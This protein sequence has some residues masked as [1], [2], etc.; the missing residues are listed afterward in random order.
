MREADE[1]MMSSYRS[2]T[3]TGLVAPGGL[4]LLAPD[5]AA[6][7][8]R[9]LWEAMVA[10]RPL[11]AWLEAIAGGSLSALPDF[12]LVRTE[13]TQVRVLV[14]GQVSVDCDGTEIRAEGMSTWREHVGPLPQRLRVSGPED[15][16][17]EWPLGSGVVAAAAVQSGSEDAERSALAGTA[18]A[19]EVDTDARKHTPVEGGPE[20]G[21]LTPDE[22]E[23]AEEPETPAE[24]EDAGAA[25]T[26]DE[27]DDAAESDGGTAGSEAG[28]D[29]GL[30]DSLP[31]NVP[32]MKAGQTS[33]GEGGEA[34]AEAE[35]ADT[36]ASAEAESADADSAA[37]SGADSDTEAAVLEAEEDDT[38][39]T[40]ESDRPG[41]A[42]GSDHFSEATVFPA[43]AVGGG[44]STGE[45]ESDHSDDVA[46]GDATGEDVAGEAN[47]DDGDHDGHTV[48]VA[49]LREALNSGGQEAV[50]EDTVLA[51]A[52]SQPARVVP[53]VVISTGQR[54]ELDRPALL[55]RA[56]EATR[57]EGPVAPH[58]VA[59]PSPQ[60]DISRTHV[61]LKPEGDHVVV[62]DL[63]STNGTVVTLPG[64][65]A[66]RLHPAEAIPVGAGAVIDLGDGVT[67]EVHN[68]QDGGGESEPVPRAGTGEP[69]PGQTPA[70]PAAPYGRPAPYRQPNPYGPTGAQAQ[71]GHYGQPPAPGSSSQPGPYGPPPQG[72]GVPP[73]PDR[74]GSAGGAGPV[75]DPYGPYQGGAR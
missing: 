35:V 65:E 24:A 6:V 14:R 31:W 11:S 72:P 49:H 27:P 47:E 41:S 64:A 13:G 62:T 5:F 57:F 36:G 63:R 33:E 2:G 12:A 8:A 66:R 38:A 7:T 32:A 50:G 68:D 23:G 16:G 40:A 1:V 44:C 15:G 48:L 43:P 51:G 34:S 71:P 18:A 53:V 60:Q 28:G 70:A 61:E 10:E 73:P 45:H 46:A 59:V 75:V 69:A 19:S 67:A 29:R 42:A 4:A 39:E 56:P 3:W 26:P 37:D 22:P 17:Q 52:G 30:I 25:E 54:V 20:E 74:Y 21:V 55:G 58:L 9:S